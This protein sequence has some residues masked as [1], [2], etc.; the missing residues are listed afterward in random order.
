I[1]RPMASASPAASSTRAET[2][3]RCRPPRSAWT[4]TARAPRETSSRSVKC[5][6]AQALTGSFAVIGF[7]VLARKIE[8]M[9]RLHRGDGMF[10][11][12]LD[13]SITLQQHA[14]QVERRNL[15]LKHHAIDEEHRH[16]IARLMNGGEENFLQ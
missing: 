14:E 4:T 12:K 16:R 1:S 15:A 8:R 6:M 9:G 7:V 10:V 2:S 11:D 13:Q 3:R 5:A